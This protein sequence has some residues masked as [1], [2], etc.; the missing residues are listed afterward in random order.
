MSAT[1]LDA[2]EYAISQG[3]AGTQAEFTA[4]MSLALKYEKTTRKDLGRVTAYGYAKSKGYTGTEEEFAELMASYA[5]VAENAAESESNSEA[6]AVGQRGGVDVDSE[7]ETYQNNS[8][9]YAEQAQ[10]SAEDAAESAAAFTTD[11]GL[12][13]A[14]KAADAKA[15]GDRLAGI[16]AAVG[17]PLVI[18]D[19]DDFDNASHTKVY[20]YVG[21]TTALY[22]NGDWYYW[23]G[24]GWESGGVYNSVAVDTDETL[25]VQGQAADA[26]A[27]GEVATEVTNI[28]NVLKTNQYVL[29]P[30]MLSWRQG[31]ISAT[32]GEY[33]SSDARVYSS[34]FIGIS[35]ISVDSA[36]IALMC[37]DDDVLLLGSMH[38]FSQSFTAEQIK[39]LYPTATYCKVILRHSDESDITP[40]DVENVGLKIYSPTSF[41]DRFFNYKTGGEFLNSEMAVGGL[42]NNGINTSASN[43]LRSIGYVKVKP[44]TIYT[45]RAS[46]N[47]SGKQ[48]FPSA[49]LYSINDYSTYRIRGSAFGYNGECSFITTENT[50]YI[51]FLFAF[52]DDSDITVNSISSIVLTEIDISYENYFIDS[53]FMKHK[54][55]PVYLGKLSALQSFFKY[56]NYYYSTQGSKLFKQDQNLTDVSEKS[57]NLGHGNSMHIGSNG[58][59]FVSGW[60]DQNVYEINIANEEIIETINLP[61]T[62]YTTCAVDDINKLMYIFQRDTG[63]VPPGNWNFICYDYENDNTILTKKTRS[64]GAIQGVDFVN[65]KIFALS[66]MG[67]NENPNYFC[68]YNT[69]G[70]VIGE[71][72]LNQFAD[73]EPEGVCVDRTDGS[74]YISFS[75]KHLYRLYCV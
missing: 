68:V 13:I 74:V 32:T 38:E 64:F 45:L 46:S 50:K 43:R 39:T 3:Y 11:T 66:G 22:T 42:S 56:G 55:I 10:A 7:D 71:Y 26:A 14:G 12:T 23:D 57:L 34:R 4:L 37:Y 29:L 31:T 41:Y 9:Y 53:A 58:N 2:F 51:R 15:T 27:V 72:I 8:K 40:E 36:E 28:K 59:A 52:D 47:V 61:T 44:N 20:V 73:S 17:S 5:T 54:V 18:T 62:G 48:V 6:W 35:N 24:D 60:D 25:S 19:P 75:D 33:Q 67:N 16:A 69:Q 49:S 30:D 65:G 1:I 70:D 63:T 21:T